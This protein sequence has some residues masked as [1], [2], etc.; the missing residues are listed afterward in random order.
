M[1]EGGVL[2]ERG[3]RPTRSKTASL[4]S[5]GTSGVSSTAKFKDE[6]PL[7]GPAM[8]SWLWPKLPAFAAHIEE[9]YHSNAGYALY[10]RTLL[11]SHTIDT[12]RAA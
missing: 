1:K 10:R 3:G 9:E 8:P 7:R 2:S 6:E 11:H 4:A 12:E 5:V